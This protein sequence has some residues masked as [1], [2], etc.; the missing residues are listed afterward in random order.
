MEHIALYVPG[1]YFGVL[2]IDSFVVCVSLT[3][4]YNRE[5]SLA[6][7]DVIQQAPLFM[8][9]RGKETKEY[10]KMCCKMCLKCK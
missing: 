2:I 3:G 5:S 7:S 4:N 6:Q 1:T 10:L 8:K 9:A